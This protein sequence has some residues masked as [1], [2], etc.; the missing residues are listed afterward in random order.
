MIN[1]RRKKVPLRDWS[2]FWWNCPY[3]R[4]VKVSMR[5]TVPSGVVLD[6]GYSMLH[7]NFYN[8]LIIMS[9]GNTFVI[10]ISIT[11]YT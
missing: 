8:I 7:V 4:N 6:G 11:K 2:K 9:P 3:T 1:Y 5:P 10:V